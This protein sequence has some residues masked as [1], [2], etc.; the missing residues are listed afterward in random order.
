[1]KKYFKPYILLISMLGLGFTSTYLSAAELKIGVVNPARVLET[2]PQVE[3]AEA[4]LKQEFEPR[5][6][7]LLNAQEDVKRMEERYRKNEAIMS[8][9]KLTD[10]RRDILS[11]ER[12]VKRE[13]DEFRE[14]YNIR[15]SEELDKLQKKIYRAIESLA[16][17]ENY[18]L[19]ISD[20]VIVASDR[21]D[22]TDKVLAELKR[23]H[24]TQ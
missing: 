12:E 20:G 17:R 18:D 23:L 7:Q 24:Q 19:I 21:V 4:R 1:M 8:E 16:K 6:Q 11:K 5:R 9:K 14:D 3:E 2:A 22:I 15:R 10:L 13:Q